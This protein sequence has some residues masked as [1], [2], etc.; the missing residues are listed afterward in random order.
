MTRIPFLL[1]FLG[2]SLVANGQQETRAAQK[3]PIQVDRY[4]QS[5]TKDF[6]WKVRSDEELRQDIEKQRAALRPFEGPALDRFGG[7]AGS[8]AKLGLK[9]TGYFHVA[10]AGGRWV[11]VTPEGNAFF[12][13]GVCTLNI[14][15]DYTV[16]KGREG[17][18]EWLP[19]AEGEF[20]TAWRPSTSGVMSFY[21][22]NWIRKYGR[23]FSLEEWTGQAVER[24]RAWG[25]NSGGAFSTFTE[26]MRKENFPHVSSL[27]V[28]SEDK[29]KNLPGKIG[30][31]T[32]MDPFAPENVAALDKAFAKNVAPRANDPLLIGYFVSNEQ[33]FEH[34]PKLLPGYKASKVPAKA[35][36]VEW[37]REKYGD[38]A[39]F[40]AAWNPARPFASF[41]H[42]LEE[43]LF[44]RSDAGAEDMRDFTSVFLEAYY[45]LIHDTFKKHDPNHLLLGSRWT[46]ATAR[47]E[48][49]VRAGGKYLDVVSINYYGYFLDREFLEK[50]N[51]WSGRPILLSEWHYSAG[52]EMGL[53]G[54]KVASQKERGLGYRHYTERAASIPV[55]I[56]HE[57]FSYGDMAIT[58]RW[59][60][61]FN[62][63]NDNIGLVNVADR[64]YDDLV[65]AARET[66]ARV[67]K[68]MFEGEP[69]FIYEGD[70]RFTGK[71]IDTVRKEVAV[72]GAL[73]A[74]IQLNGT[75]VNWPGTPAEPIESG[76]LSN[77]TPNAGL[78]ADFRLSWDKQNLHFLIQV[79]DQTPA[80]N[81]HE[82]KDLWKGDCV[83]LFIAA[84]DTGAKGPFRFS[85]RQILLGASS[86]PSIFIAD[87][88]EEA[89]ACRSVVIPEGDG[90]GYVLQASIPWSVI[91]L[92]PKIGAKF[93]F[94]VAVD[95]SDDGRA[96]TQQLVWNRSTTLRDREALGMARLEN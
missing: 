90:K 14:I 92:E 91:G 67:Y 64:F 18:Y 52:S 59:F 50:V 9:A 1:A 20:A 57:W 21:I 93:L 24:V 73:P 53:G 31:A 13:L 56:G 51:A 36:L 80:K 5:A 72:N 94:N 76:S 74:G 95:N 69:P 82:G 2:A 6:P 12:Q 89:A 62:G 42:L 81:H 44:V 29:I 45:R 33:H 70:S 43:P 38:I 30:A 58:G 83:E 88:P 37:L 22:A 35:R 63:Q 55:V 78:R 27:P 49:I 87:H 48:Y 79:K 86:N 61:G 7:L 11:F 71:G 41:D 8:G 54:N 40:N 84:K 96:R 26:T 85:D 34:L 15:D 47:N 66:N 39:K 10:R 68:I 3:S 60:S 19:A 32:I 23:P 46:P 4:G 28:R 77:G 25:F 17:V 16:V 75:T 65:A